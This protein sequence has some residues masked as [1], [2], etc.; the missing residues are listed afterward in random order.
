MSIYVIAILFAISIAIILPSLRWLK[1]NYHAVYF[2]N[3]P[4]HMVGFR[5]L[6]ISDL[7]NRSSK[8]KT[9]DIW[10]KIRKMKEN[11]QKKLPFDIAVITGDVVLRR[12]GQIIPHRED[13]VWLAS[14]VPTFYVEGNH[15]SPH[16][17]KISLFLEE[18]GIKCLYNEKVTIEHNGG[19]VDVIGTKDFVQLRKEKYAGLCELFADKTHFSV[20]LTHQP[21]VWDKFKDSQPDFTLSGHTHGGQVRLPFLPTLYAPRQGIFPKYGRGFYYHG[22]SKLYV[23]VGVGATDFP[24]RFWNRPAI[25]IFEL[26]EQL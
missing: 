25:E 24:L 10:Q 9:F 1:I 4:K 7:H 23:S 20:V 18:C 3:L 6:Q 15:D 19:L 17:G 16:Y 11:P 13:F 14:H 22:N 5:V 26:F 21:Q 2:E 8:K 12:A